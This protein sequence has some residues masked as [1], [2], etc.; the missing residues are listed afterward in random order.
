MYLLYC[1]LLLSGVR[2]PGTCVLLSAREYIAAMAST[3][4]VEIK[5]VDSST[6]QEKVL[7]VPSPESMGVGA[8]GYDESAETEMDVET[9]GKVAFAARRRVLRG[10]TAEAV[11]ASFSE[12][13]QQYPVLFDKCCDP[14][15]SMHKLDFL[16]TQLASARAAPSDHEAATDRVIAEL[17]RTYVDG[18]VEDLERQRVA[19]GGAPA[20]GDQHA[21]AQ[22]RLRDRLSKARSERTARH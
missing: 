19:Q 22:R 18:V 3:S 15:F 1:M 5:L 17:N 8:Q 6:G 7:T 16:L 10:E 4:N 21:E 11:R 9:I 20:D 2:A 12:F 14:A 13:A